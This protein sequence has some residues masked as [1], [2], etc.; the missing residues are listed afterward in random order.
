VI[1]HLCLLSAANIGAGFAL[2]AVLGRR[3][4]KLATRRQWAPLSASRPRPVVVPVRPVAAPVSGQAAAV[5]VV[6]AGPLPKSPGHIAVDDLFDCVAN[7]GTKLIEADEQLRQCAASPD[8]G[9]I[10][11]LLRKIE[12]TARNFAESRDSAQQR[13]ADL[14]R[15]DL[16]WEGINNEIFVA[17]Q[18]QDAEIKAI[19]QEIAGFDY[20]SDLAAGCRRIV[21]RTHRLLNSN[22]VLRDALEKALAEVAQQED[23]PPEETD[24]SDPL[25]GCV[26]RAGIEADLHAWWASVADHTRLCLAAIDIDR[27]AETNAQH[28]YRAGNGILKAVAK[29][30]DANR[31]DNVRVARFSGQRF[32]VMYSDVDKAV[33][34]ETIE[35]CRQMIDKAQFKHKESDFHITVSG[36]LAC[37]R[38]DDSPS[39]LLLRLDAALREAKRY[40]RNRTFVYEGKYPT[41]VAPPEFQVEP[42]QIA[43]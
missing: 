3:Y 10:E 38:N 37:G 31:A 15:S 23:C 34:T 33:A 13:I 22:D 19:C 20:E 39:S 12:A 42:L 24:R 16:A 25:T 28:G 27:L 36:A 30:L 41:P 7:F 43:I 4:Q 40:G 21:G 1:L 17:D 11:S 9:T 26:N 32:L 18:M 6:P 5:R 2:A 35:R 8:L 29:L 14:T